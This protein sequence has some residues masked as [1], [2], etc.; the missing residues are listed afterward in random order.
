MSYRTLQR[1][2]F[3]SLWP[4]VVLVLAFCFLKPYGMSRVPDVIKF[5]Q[6]STCETSACFLGRCFALLIGYYC[7]KFRYDPCIPFRRVLINFIFLYL[8]YIPLTG[9]LLCVIHYFYLP[10]NPHWDNPFTPGFWLSFRN[11]CSVVTMYSVFFYLI[12]VFLFR[13]RQTRM[14]LEDV[15]LGDV[16]QETIP[17][18]HQFI[19]DY[20]TDQKSFLSLRQISNNNNQESMDQER[21]QTILRRANKI[22]SFCAIS[23]LIL[24]LILTFLELFDVRI[25]VGENRTV[26]LVVFCIVTGVF[27]ISNEVRGYL[28]MLEKE[29]SVGRY[30][31]NL[32][33]LWSMNVF[34]LCCVHNY[35]FGSSYSRVLPTAIAFATIIA[36]SHFSYYTLYRVYFERKANVA[37]NEML[38][39][40]LTRH[41]APQPEEESDS[42]SP[43]Q[44][45]LHSDYGDKDLVFNPRDFIYAESISNYVSVSYLDDND[46]VCSAT[47]RTTLKQIKE[48]LAGHDSIVQ[49]HRGFLVNLRCAKS[50][51]GSSNCFF[52][53]LVNMEK[54]IP[55]SRAY[56]TDIK[57]ALLSYQS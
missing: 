35:I 54:K 49:C 8:L 43:E 51:E 19:P 17:I 45:T 53:H 15:S 27:M 31:W 24:F 25:N 22:C 48:D 34:V 21:R 9:F 13:F 39:Q 38:R 5:I 26:R 12:D 33:I 30:A 6:I 55:V 3:D 42:F 44:C 52:L 7:L 29:T 28:Q 16:A 40:Q 36:G 18:G 46:N 32:I 41:E 10:E 47:L 14:L 23:L 1:I 56:K 57:E 11:N 37:I 50:L 4:C 20:C 2:L